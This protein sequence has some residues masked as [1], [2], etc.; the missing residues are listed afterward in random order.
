MSVMVA[1]KKKGEEKGKKP[2]KS[3]YRYSYILAAAS[4]RAIRSLNS[5]AKRSVICGNGPVSVSA[6]ALGS[7]ARVCV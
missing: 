4:L 5:R 7:C 3:E 1:K 6:A 2:I